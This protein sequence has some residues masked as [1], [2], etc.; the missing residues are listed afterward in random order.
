MSAKFQGAGQRGSVSTQLGALGK[1]RA[2]KVP[3]SRALQNCC[4]PPA[5]PRKIVRGEG[6]GRGLGNGPQQHQRRTTKSTG[7]E[8]RTGKDYPRRWGKYRRCDRHDGE[9][10]EEERGMQEVVETKI[11]NKFPQENV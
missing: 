11:I 8:Q 5:A 2:A 4:G 1:E 3:P 9:A 7:P 6:R 10:E